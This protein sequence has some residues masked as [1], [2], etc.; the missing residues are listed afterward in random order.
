MSDKEYSAEM[1]H[2]GELT[3]NKAFVVQ[4]RVLHRVFS[5]RFDHTVAADVLQDSDVTIDAEHPGGWWTTLLKMCLG[6]TSKTMTRVLKLPKL[7]SDCTTAMAHPRTCCVN[8]AAA[9]VSED[10]CPPDS[11]SFCRLLPSFVFKC[12]QVVG[13]TDP[14]WEQ[15]EKPPASK[16]FNTA[17]H[18]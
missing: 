12:F 2:R 1:Y 6:D 11:W 18:C 8:T 13:I 4:T 15:T 7:Q 14:G 16:P 5:L 3:S 17:N 9:S 10:W